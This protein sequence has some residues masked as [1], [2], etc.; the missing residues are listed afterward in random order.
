MQNKKASITLYIS[1]LIFA[2][3]IIIITAVLAPMGVIFN[4]E[5]Y[6]AG[7]KLLEDANESIQGISDATVKAQVQASL[8]EAKNAGANNIEIN[9]NMFQYAWIIIIILVGLMIFLITRSLTEIQGG[10][11]I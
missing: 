7:E 9:N 4:T 6:L 2:I 3:V 10:G 8:N 1:F 11:V 5:M